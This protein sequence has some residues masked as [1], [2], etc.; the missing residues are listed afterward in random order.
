MALMSPL[1]KLN[2]LTALH[3]AACK[4]VIAERTGSQLLQHASLVNVALPSYLAA[5][6][7]MRMC[8]T[9]LIAYLA[10]TCWLLNMSFF[11]TVASQTGRVLNAGLGARYA[12]FDAAHRPPGYSI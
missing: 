9:V 12:T 10:D 2:W 4:R 8:D 3:I 1:L 7:N 6:W 11:F 5:G